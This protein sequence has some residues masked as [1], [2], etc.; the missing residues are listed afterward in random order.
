MEQNTFLI[1]LMIIVVGFFIIKKNF[2]VA[3]RIRITPSEA[4]KRL[5]E[6]KGIILLDVRTKEEYLD[7]KDTVLS[8]E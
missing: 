2:G 7:T 4:K 1:I 3:A 5:D 8:L 6:E